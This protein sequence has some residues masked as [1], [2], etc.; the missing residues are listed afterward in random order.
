MG[1]I[2]HLLPFPHSK[3]KQKSSKPTH[4]K[5]SAGN[6]PDCLSLGRMLGF[7]FQDGLQLHFKA[8]REA[9][10]ADTTMRVSRERRL[11]VLPP[12]ALCSHLLLQT[13]IIPPDNCRS[14]KPHPTGF[15]PSCLHWDYGRFLL[16]SSSTRPVLHQW[17]PIILYELLNY[18]SVLNVLLCDLIKY[19]SNLRQWLRKVW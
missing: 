12:W 4:F 17:F 3:P 18:L 2:I 13:E 14:L 8:Q 6:A 15:P 1:S 19:T 9:R 10:R 16:A 5:S 7:Y 11:E